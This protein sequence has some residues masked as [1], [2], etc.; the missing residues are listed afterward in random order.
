MSNP[1]PQS[2]ECPQAVARPPADPVGPLVQKPGEK[3]QRALGLGVSP[4]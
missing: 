2:P 4:A 1:M 3:M